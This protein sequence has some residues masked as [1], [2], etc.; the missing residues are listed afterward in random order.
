MPSLIGLCLELVRTCK[1]DEEVPRGGTNIHY[2]PVLVSTKTQ[3]N[4]LARCER[5]RIKRTVPAGRVATRTQ[6]RLGGR[7]PLPSH[8]CSRELMSIFTSQEVADLLLSKL[9]TS[10]PSKVDMRV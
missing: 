9:V 10:F 2:P 5:N 8:P 1:T 7:I 4:L 3:H 6:F